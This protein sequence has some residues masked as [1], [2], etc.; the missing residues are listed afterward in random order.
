V[1]EDCRSCH[2]VRRGIALGKEAFNKK[3]TLMLASLSLHL[4]K[5]MVKAFVWIVDLY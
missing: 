5:H 3:K 2:E 4:K 1:T